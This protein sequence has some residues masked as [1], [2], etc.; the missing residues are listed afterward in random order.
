MSVKVRSKGG[1]RT[2]FTGACIKYYRDMPKEPVDSGRPC[3]Y[4][5]RVGIHELVVIVVS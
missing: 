4:G 2:Y 1:K 3:G 5:S